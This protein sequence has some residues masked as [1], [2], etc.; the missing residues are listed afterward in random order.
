MFYSKLINQA[1]DIS[2]NAHL[3]QKDKAG[4]PYFI[5]PF[6]VAQQMENE[7]EICTA[8]LHD[9]IEDTNIKL[10]ELE[11]I[12]PREIT[13]AVKVLTHQE[14]IDYFDYI[15]RIKDNPI[16]RKVKLADLRHNLDV[17]RIIDN[18]ELLGD[19]ERRR[20]KYERARALLEI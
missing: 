16:A 15:L 19:Y 20:K 3:G 18:P 10:E 9:V 17:T 7:A 14:G 5:H 2:F 4:R 13:E 1:I 8:L 6:S 12:F 11:K